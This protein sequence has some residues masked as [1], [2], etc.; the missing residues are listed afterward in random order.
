[1]KVTVFCATSVDGFIAR[2]DGALDWLDAANATVPAGT[3]LGF[4]ALLS[5]VDALV[6]GRKSY[7]KVRSFG[8]WPYGALPVIVRSRGSVEIPEDLAATVSAS[9]ES[10]PELLKR[11]AAQ[12]HRHLYVDGGQTVQDFLRAGLV[13][14]LVITLIPVLLGEGI[15]LF[16]RLPQDVRLRL[17]GT[18]ATDFGFVQLRYQRLS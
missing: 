11:L 9:G 12:G 6:M 3:D 4:A 17:M 18:T 8:E 10:A 2:P 1:M 13:T 14:D 16:G 5:E 7:E 15:P